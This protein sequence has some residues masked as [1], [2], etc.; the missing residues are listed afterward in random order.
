MRSSLLAPQSRSL[1]EFPAPLLSSFGA[2]A[3]SKLI[4]ARINS[5]RQLLSD[6]L[7]KLGTVSETDINHLALAEQLRAKLAAFK[8]MVATVAMHLDSEW[9]L[10]LLKTLDRLLAPDDWEKDFRLP[11]EQ[12]FST[13]LRMIIYLH[14]TK[15]PGLGLLIH[16]EFPGSLDGR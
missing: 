5:I 9:R 10:E 13:F 7:K 14:P 4:D 2:G 16:G 1:F 3:D 12:S 15:R 6:S 11:S 8:R